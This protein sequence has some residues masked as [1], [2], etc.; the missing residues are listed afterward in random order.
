[1]VLLDGAA[2]PACLIPMLDKFRLIE[3]D[4]TDEAFMSYG[5]IT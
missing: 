5:P 3:N 1:M 4:E 2:L